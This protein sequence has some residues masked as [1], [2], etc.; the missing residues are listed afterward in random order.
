MHDRNAVG[1]AMRGRRVAADA[2]TAR[3]QGAAVPGAKD[4][5]KA[6]KERAVAVA[7]ATKAVEPAAG[8]AAGRTV[9][10]DRIHRPK[11]ARTLHLVYHYALFITAR[12]AIYTLRMRVAG[13][14]LKQQ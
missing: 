13:T 1:R 14:P 7:K 6:A 10:V 5:A 9:Q 8:A 11:E 4:A 2:T 3:G 12:P